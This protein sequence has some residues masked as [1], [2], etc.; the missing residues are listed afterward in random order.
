MY[1]KALLGEPSLLKGV[2]LAI[3]NKA[4]NRLI[5]D[6][7]LKKDHCTFWIGYTISPFHAKQGYAYEVLAAIVAWVKQKGG[8]RIKASVSPENIPSINLLKK[9]KFTYLS[10]D[11][12]EHLYILDLQKM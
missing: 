8:V 9:L 4:T 6:I 7:Y 12:G 5:G 1:A 2:Q 11:E 10:S 3:I